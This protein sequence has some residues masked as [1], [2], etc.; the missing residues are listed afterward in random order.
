MTTSA[1]EGS[2]DILELERR[3]AAIAAAYVVGR[4][5]RPVVLSRSDEMT[6]SRWRPVP[7]DSTLEDNP[8]P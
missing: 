3:E 8:R 4:L 6:G 5:P 2:Y 1:F 7:D